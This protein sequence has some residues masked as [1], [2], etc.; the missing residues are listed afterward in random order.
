MTTLRLILADQLSELLVS[1]R[2]AHKQSDIIM[3]FELMSE[4]TYVPPHPKKISFLFAAR[5]YF[6]EKLRCLLQILCFLWLDLE[7]ERAGVWPQWFY[8]LRRNATIGVVLV[9]IAIMV[10]L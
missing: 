7:L 3:L 5:R 6:A 9:M 1:L 10:S 8:N 4:A 2:G